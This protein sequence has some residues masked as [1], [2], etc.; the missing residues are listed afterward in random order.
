MKIL[1]NRTSSFNLKSNILYTLLGSLQ[2]T[3]PCSFVTND[4]LVAITYVD[5]QCSCIN[6]HRSELEKESGV[7]TVTALSDTT[8]CK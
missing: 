8:L 6:V 5:K 4:T 3:R 2:R 7:P 1:V